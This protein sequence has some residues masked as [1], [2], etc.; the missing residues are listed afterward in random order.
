MFLICL[1][2]LHHFELSQVMDFGLDRPT[3]HHHLRT[4]DLDYFFS[5]QISTPSKGH[6]MPAGSQVVS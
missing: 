3:H 5:R 2:H 6:N 4:Q 1:K